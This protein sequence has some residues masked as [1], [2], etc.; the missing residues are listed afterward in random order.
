MIGLAPASSGYI[1]V[2]IIFVSIW[3]IAK[4]LWQKIISSKENLQEK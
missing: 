4:R 3:E 1:F 2:G